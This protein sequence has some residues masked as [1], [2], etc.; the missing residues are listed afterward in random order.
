[1]KNR[2]I[3]HS[4]ILNLWQ[5]H[6]T[7]KKLQVMNQKSKRIKTPVLV[8]FLVLFFSINLSA[9]PVN[10]N[11]ANT[12]S[13][14]IETVSNNLRVMPNF[15]AIAPNAV[16]PISQVEPYSHLADVF[17]I[18]TDAQT[19]VNLNITIVDDAT[20]NVVFTDDNP[21]GTI[22]PNTLV[23][24]Q[25]FL[26]Y[27]T[28]NGTTPTSYTATYEVTSDSVDI[29]PSDNTRTYSLATSET[30]FAKE[31]GGTTAIWPAASNWDPGE[32]HSWAYGNYYYIVDGDNWDA[33]SVDFMIGNAS[34]PGLANRI[35]SVFL[36]RWDEDFN[37]DGNMDPDERTRVAY[38]F[39][40]I[41]GTETTSD[42]IHVSLRDFLTDEP[43]PIDIE[44]NQAY[45]VMVEYISFDQVDFAMMAGEINYNA[46]SYRSELDGIP[47]GAARYGSL[48]GIDEQFYDQPYST[49]GFNA[50]LAPVVRLNI[51]STQ[52]TIAG[53]VTNVSCNG[54]CSGSI[55]ISVNCENPNYTYS[56][57][58]P[59]GYM[60]TSENISGLC[61]GV[62]EVVVTSSNGNSESATYTIEE[63]A[64][65]STDTEIIDA[66]CFQVCD[67]T[68]DLTVNGGVTPYTYNWSNASMDED[69]TDLCAEHFI[70]T[71]T[72]NN[73][74]TIIDSTTI[75]EPP[76]MV[77]GFDYAI[78]PCAFPCEDSIYLTVTNGI[79]PLNFQWFN[80]FGALISTEKDLVNI[81]PGMYTV[82]VTD[83]NDCL[84]EGFSEITDPSFPAASGSIQDVSCFEL[85][86]GAIDLEINGGVLPY[87]Y[88]WSGGLPP[89]EDQIFLC[90]GTYTVTITDS[91]GCSNIVSIYVS[92]PSELLVT[93]ETGNP[94][95]FDDCNGTATI[96]AGGG[97]PPY[98]FSGPTEDL[99]PGNYTSTI[100]DAN[101]C[102]VI[103]SY[104]IE[105]TP[106][107][108]LTIDS[109]GDE[110]DNMMNGFINITPGGGTPPFTFV[111]SNGGGVV[112]TDEDP[113]GLSAG[114][115][116]VEI[117]DANGCVLV[118]TDIIV[119][120]IVAISQ[121]QLDNSITVFPNPTSGI[122]QIK[123]DLQEPV[124][125]VLKIYDFTGRLIGSREESNISSQSIPIDLSHYSDGVYT[126]KIKVGDNF[127]VKKIVKYQW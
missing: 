105:E 13:V 19:N 47:N 20:N 72:D 59:G 45:A 11:C 22:P 23:E 15:Y 55:D 115:Y 56:W 74:C 125:S 81:C 85:C 51:V 12:F 108:T 82:I 102:T 67:G 4:F 8:V 24:N 112:S 37:Q 120:N 35:L 121:I 54:E 101:G 76:E 100:T 5:L 98:T 118:L 122:V 71:I 93:V 6:L 65:I 88:Q 32:P 70:V 61:P 2:S 43:A 57:S 114:S 17:N 107:L 25:P 117:T 90:A 46:M 75:N 63:P 73:G 42:L 95:C 7:T 126:L 94:I 116:E 92:E 96:S 66:S 9:Q 21:Y 50:P 18:G 123:F 77:L 109:L 124:S 58:G 68:I 3:L 97:I 26:N 40:L 91:L 49:I 38:G 110:M 87:T 1:M 33:C 113:S 39:Y 28:P 52:I 69:L 89:D 80:S 44:S 31:F 30:V 103:S 62:Y 16:T 60:E 34:N 104:E 86:D 127:I 27:F 53:D 41:E 106:E 79:P 14:N 78:L 99:C 84:I 111:W 83:A 10:D 64:Q 48:L 119:D 29:N 36:Y